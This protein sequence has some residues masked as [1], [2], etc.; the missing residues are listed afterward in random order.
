MSVRYRRTGVL[1]DF[2]LDPHHC[3]R[4]DP[5]RAFPGEFCWLPGSWRRSAPCGTVEERGVASLR[6]AVPAMRAEGEPVDL[7][8]TGRFPRGRC[9]VGVH[10]HDAA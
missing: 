6:R 7:G 5:W 8:W 4:G 2:A 1:V 10:R 3:A 9:D